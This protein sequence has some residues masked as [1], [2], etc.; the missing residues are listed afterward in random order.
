MTENNII[1]VACPVGCRIKIESAAGEIKDINGY[2][3]E[4][5]RN[6]AVEEFKN[7]TRILPT[8]VRV[9]NGDLPLVSVKTASP[10][11]KGDLLVAMEELARVE[12]E[13]PVTCGQVVLENVVDSGVD[14][15]ATNNVN[16]KSK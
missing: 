2:Q 3:C 15:V 14:V 10:I 1:C 12:V 5:G 16:T 11:P 7:P 13:A 4:Q 8:T 9:K 6:Y